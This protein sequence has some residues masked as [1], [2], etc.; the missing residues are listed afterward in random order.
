MS[1]QPVEIRPVRL[2]RDV[3]DGKA[4]H[5]EF[6][7]REGDADLDVAVRASG[8]GVVKEILDP[9]PLGSPADSKGRRNSPRCFA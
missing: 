9:E 7:A 2:I 6:V 3:G 4:D 8:F 1:E 5:G